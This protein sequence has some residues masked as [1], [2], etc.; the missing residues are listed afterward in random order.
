M[1]IIM[2]VLLGLSLLLLLISFFQKDPYKELKEELDQLTLQHV[3]EIYQMK[4]RLR[5]LEEELL[6]SEDHFT[7][8]SNDTRDIH[9]IIKNQVFSLAQQGK[10]I[11]QIASQS[12]LSKKDVYSILEEYAE[13]GKRD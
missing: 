6:V 3:Q 2:M 13:V 9:E 11:E 4:Q 1:G 8:V 7:T 12:S 5:I 10:T